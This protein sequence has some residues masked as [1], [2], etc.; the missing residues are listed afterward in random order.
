MKKLIFIIDDDREEQDIFNIVL[1]HAGIA[2][3]CI[4]ADGAETALRMLQKLQ[5]GFIFLDLN[6][7]KINGLACLPALRRMENLRQVP[8]FL[9]STYIS[10]ETRKLAIERGAS[11]CIEKPDS[12]K[13]LLEILQEVLFADRFAGNTAT[14]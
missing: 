6:M 9:Y 3:D 8:I 1:D 12:E 5:P 7:P 2:H 11:K 4:W 10:D 14:C 13:V